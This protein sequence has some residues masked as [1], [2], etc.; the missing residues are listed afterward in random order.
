M[1]ECTHRSQNL[2]SATVIHENHVQLS[3]GSEILFDN[4]R[5]AGLSHT[6][7]RHRP[8]LTPERKVDEPLDGETNNPP[9]VTDKLKDATKTHERT[10]KTK[11][12]VLRVWKG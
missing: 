6:T 11:S 2:P 4:L 8:P 7:R 5:D 10:D 3:L 12:G 1:H 9:N